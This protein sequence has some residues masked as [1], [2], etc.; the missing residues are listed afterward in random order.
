MKVNS[1]KKGCCLF[2]YP[3][4]DKPMDYSS[5]KE[6]STYRPDDYCMDHQSF[7]CKKPPE[8]LFSR[9]AFFKSSMLRFNYDF[10]KNFFFLP[11]PA[12]PIRPEPKSSMVAGSGTK[13]PRTEG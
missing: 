13:S 7:R 6:K 10:L 9:A 2:H 1:D 4:D 11:N 5:Q 12:R 8:N 3:E